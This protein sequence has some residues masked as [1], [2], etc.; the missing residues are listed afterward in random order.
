MKIKRLCALLLALIMVFALVACS[1][2]EEGTKK[3]EGETYELAVHLWVPD[4]AVDLTKQQIEAFNA[5]NTYNIKVTPTIDALSEADSATQVL[6]D[7]TTAADMYFFAQDQFA[8]LV[9]GGALAAIPSEMVATI[10][11]EN[12]ASVVAAG[13]SGDTQYAYPLTNDNGYFMYYDKSVIPESDLGSLEKLIADCEAA[14]KYFAFE[15]DTSAW[16]LASFFFGVGCHSNWLL[17]DDGKIVSVDDDFNSDKGLIAVKGMEKLVKSPKYLSSSDVQ[18]FANGAAIVVS[19]TWAYTDVK[20]ILGDNLGACELPSFEVDG[21]TYHLGS[22]SGCKLLGVKPQSDGNR[23][24]A[25]HILAQYLTSEAAQL[26]RFNALAWGPANTAAA[27]NEAVMANPA[28]VALNA[29]N[30]Y[31]VPQGQIDGA[32]WDIGKVIGSEVKEAKSEDDLKA[33]LANYYEK[34]SAIFT[35]SE[36]DKNAWGVIGAICGTNWDTD[37]PMTADGNLFKSEALELKAG[38][39]LKCR[40][41]GS[42]DN[43]FP[44]DNVKVEADGFY[45]V[46]LDPEAGTVTLEPGEAPGWGVIGAICGTNWDTDFP[47]T[48]KGDGT[49]ESEALELKA[50]DELKCR[51]AGS[52]DE[53]MGTDGPNGANLKVEADGTYIV[54]LDTNANTISLKE[55]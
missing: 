33:A 4:A 46:V 49:F 6:N 21:Q 28:L 19:G 26:E 31:A 55:G 45:V 14:N 52:W 29:Q 36:E 3:P 41:G 1:G 12:N 13:K 39:E 15:M 48:D 53:N 51:F 38:D 8:R 9:R 37:F 11:A 5:N 23:A 35:M 22:F 42:W 10:A 50:G 27:A 18:E 2:N 54:V 32:W 20:N 40:Q 43:N 30:Q 34:I 24:A 16:S 25:I 44:A 17:D 7:V 47:M